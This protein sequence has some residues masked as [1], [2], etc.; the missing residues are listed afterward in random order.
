MTAGARLIA[1]ERDRQIAEEGFSEEHDAQ[2]AER[3]LA[4]AA[5][6]YLYSYHTGYK[7]TPG[8]WP[9]GWDQ[10]LWKVTGDKKR[11]LVKAGALVAAELDRL[12]NAQAALEYDMEEEDA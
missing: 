8:S 2:H 6:A 12:L 3:Q 1:E 10:K 4:G 11:L 5:R 7:F 9:K